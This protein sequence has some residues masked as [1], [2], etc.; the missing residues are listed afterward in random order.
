M[1]I[2]VT[3]CTVYVPTCLYITFYAQLHYSVMLV[4]NVTYFVM[5]NYMYVCADD[6]FCCSISNCST[7]LH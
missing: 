4:V 1:T 3:A 7:V 6:V 5:K 2:M